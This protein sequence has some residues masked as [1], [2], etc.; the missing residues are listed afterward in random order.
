MRKLNISIRNCKRFKKHDGTP[1]FGD[2]ILAQAIEYSEALQKK[3]HQFQRD[4]NRQFLQKI[5]NHRARSRYLRGEKQLEGPTVYFS[6]KNGQVSEG[7]KFYA[8][9]INRNTD[10]PEMIRVIRGGWEK[11]V[12]DW[13]QDWPN[14]TEISGDIIKKL[15]IIH[16]P[17]EY[18][19]DHSEELSPNNVSFEDSSL[20]NSDPSFGDQ[21]PGLENSD[22]SFGDLDLG[23]E[24]SDTPFHSFGD[25]DS[26]V[27]PLYGAVHGQHEAQIN[28]DSQYSDDSSFGDLL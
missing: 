15:T 6:I 20:E 18:A 5:H 4:F 12:S 17:I 23:S 26:T 22:S 13:P 3:A 24:D 21:N 11:G 16:E 27:I 19:Q 28:T 1:L 9:I 7:N 14:E 25:L 10:P 8:T 2:I